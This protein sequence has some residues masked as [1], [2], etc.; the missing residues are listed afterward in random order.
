M[1]RLTII[2]CS[3]AVIL[4]SGCTGVLKSVECFTECPQVSEEP[5]DIELL[6]DARGSDPLTHV[7]ATATGPIELGV[8]YDAQRVAVRELAHLKGGDGVAW[9][10]EKDGDVFPERGLPVPTIEDFLPLY[11]KWQPSKPGGAFTMEDGTQLTVLAARDPQAVRTRWLVIRRDVSGCGPCGGDAASATVVHASAPQPPAD[12]G[13]TSATVPTLSP[14]SRDERGTRF[15]FRPGA[16]ASHVFVAGE[17]NAWSPTASEMLDPDG[18]GEYE[19]FLKLRPGTYQYKF[20]ADGQWHHD[21]G[22]P[23]VTPDTFGGSNS[24]IVVPQED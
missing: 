2:A 13:R 18:D 12:L 6:G 17:F 23:N 1:K 14:A 4:L 16:G 7:I 19:I 22:N 8:D 20:V 21:P 10:T 5:D 9:F 3:F 11:N 15:A 24:V